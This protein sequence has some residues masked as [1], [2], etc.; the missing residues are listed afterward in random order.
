MLIPPDDIDDLD[1][2]N[3]QNDFVE[4]YHQRIK[5]AEALKKRIQKDQIMRDKDKILITENWKRRGVVFNYT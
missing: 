3:R 2:T 1:V 5:Q 4:K